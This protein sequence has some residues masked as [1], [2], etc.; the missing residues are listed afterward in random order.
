MR[1]FE[2]T[3]DPPV[4]RVLPSNYTFTMDGGFT[5]NVLTNFGVRKT[6]KTQKLKFSDIYLMALKASQV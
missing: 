1:S 5:W 6:I 2:S 4:G 3:D